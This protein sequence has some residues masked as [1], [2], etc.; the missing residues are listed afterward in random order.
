MVGFDNH[1]AMTGDWIPPH[2]SPRAF[3]S[4]LLGNDVGARAVEADEQ[5]VKLNAPSDQKMSS[6]GGLVERMAARAGFKAPR[7]NTLGT[8]PSAMSLNQEVRSPYLYIPDGLSPSILLDSPV[9]LSNSLVQP[10]PTTGKFL[11]A[12]GDESKSVTSM[13]EAV[14]KRKETA[15]ASNYSSSFFNPI[16]ETD[17]V[18]LSSL[19]QQRFPQI[20]V[21][22]HPDNSLQNERVCHQTSVINPEARTFKAL[23]GSMEHSPS[24]DEQQ[25]EDTEQRGGEDSNVAGA[26]AEDGYNWRKYGQKQVKRSEYPQSYYKCTHPNCHVKKKIIYDGV[27]NHPK[28]LPNQRS[29][30]G[31]SNS[32]GDMQLDNVDPS[33]TGVND[34]LAFATIQQGP[35]SGGLEWRNDN[36][37]ATS[38]AALH[39]EYFN[40]S[41]T[42]RADAVQLGSADGVDVSSTFSNDEDDRGTHGSVSLGYDGAG[43]ESESKRRKIEP[44]ATNTSGASK[45]I[46]E[47]RVVVRTISEVDILDDGY[48]WRKYGQKVVKG[49]PNPRS[50]YKCTSPGCNVRKHIE[51]DSHDLKSVITTYD[52]KHNHDVPTARKSSQANSGVSK[53]LSNPITNNA[54]SRVRYGRAPSLSSFGPTPGFNSFRT[55]QGG[56]DGLAMAGLN[57]DQH[58]LPV[59]VHPYIGQPQPVND[60]GFLLPNGEPL[61][62]PSLNISNGSS[63]YQQIEKIPSSASG[64]NFPNFA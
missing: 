47:P 16:M 12:S 13:T 23:G 2:P 9:F 17:R 46:R 4:S 20:E 26:S 6:R 27:H 52:G 49:N 1:V 24:V 28:P 56:L 48:R 30:L 38:S 34:E 7:L 45:A 63:T 54:Q 22:D 35:T 59:P 57:A 33:G 60:A 19:S 41:T 31:S 29:A 36:L 51:R 8:R 53:S 40:E 15:S 55:S 3:F 42:L 11:F 21:S 62:N 50:Y 25:D 18:N 14:D 39:S 5:T 10:S 44:Y 58:Q 43:D 32:F 37:E 64:V 61:S